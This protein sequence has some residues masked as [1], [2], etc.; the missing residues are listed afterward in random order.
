[1]G[2][3]TSSR[4][5]YCSQER[6]NSKISAVLLISR[7]NLFLHNM[8]VN[9]TWL[10]IGPSCSKHDL[11]NSGLR[12]HCMTKKNRASTGFEP[13]VTS[14]NTGA[15]FYTTWEWLEK[16]NHILLI[17]PRTLVLFF[18]WTWQ[19]VPWQLVPTSSFGLISVTGILYQNELGLTREPPK[20]TSLLCT[21]RQNKEKAAK[22]V[23]NN[24]IIK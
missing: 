17:L 6:S 13:V 1:M 11:A 23:V 20:D 9:L 12:K 10:H 3:G 5:D 19:D 22:Y 15:L 24:L 16:G 21:Q 14:A 8:R 2:D 4:V 7:E 18:E